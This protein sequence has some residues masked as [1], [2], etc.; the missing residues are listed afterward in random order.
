[1]PEHQHLPHL[2]P[3]AG[4]PIVFITVVTHERRHILANEQAHT[5]LAGVWSRSA[6]IDG[7]SVG[8]YV[9]MPDHVHLFARGAQDAKPLSKWVQT[10]KSITSRQLAATCNVEPPIWQRDYFD[11]FLRS[12]D[13]YSE[14]WNYVLQN[15]V[16]AGLVS[17]A[18]EW[19]G[20]GVIEDLSF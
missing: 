7:W 9:I 17:S 15:P 5:V 4:R 11:R 18:D 14:K 3:L 12:A 2:R 16:R 19:S 10:W 1:M 6:T 8:R 13:S 20:Q